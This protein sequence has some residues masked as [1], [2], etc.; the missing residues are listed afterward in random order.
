M[1]P[2]KF[3]TTQ[4]AAKI[5]GISKQTLCRYEKKGVFPRAGRNMVNRWRQYSPEDIRRLKSIMGRPVR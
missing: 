2:E 5:L 3:F 4:E 1:G